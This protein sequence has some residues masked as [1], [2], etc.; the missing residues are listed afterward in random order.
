VVKRKIEWFEAKT[1]LECV[2]CNK[3]IEIGD[4]YCLNDTG[5]PMHYYCYNAS[6]SIK[7]EGTEKQ[8]D[9]KEAEGGNNGEK[10]LCRKRIGG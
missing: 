7:E 4:H 1:I 2:I 10:E 9:S 8:T 5:E 3:D 6:I